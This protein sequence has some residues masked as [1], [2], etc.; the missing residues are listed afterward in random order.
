MAAVQFQTPNVLVG[1]DSGA[2]ARPTAWDA[3]V[4]VM[5][6]RGTQRAAGP[7]SD[8]WQENGNAVST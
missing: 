2:A 8:T 5:P 7:S 1:L 6:T 3:D 4:G